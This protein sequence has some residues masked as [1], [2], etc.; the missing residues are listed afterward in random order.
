M[1]IQSWAEVTYSSLLNIWQGLLSYLPSLLGAIIVLVIGLIVAAVF[2]TAVDR[3][4]KAL[5]LDSLL[6]KVGLNEY[7]ERAGIQINSG[8]FFGLLIYWFLIVVF[9][10]AASDLLNLWGISLFL[11]DIIGYLPNII[12][13]V[14]IM[15]SAVILAK[16]LKSLVRASVLSAK[17]H[18]SKFLGTLT[19]WSVVI[20]GLLA[21]LLQLGI[22]TTII[23]TLI[24]GIIAMMALAG[25][26]A[27][28]LGG[29]EYAAHL[30]NKLREETEGE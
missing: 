8:K 5:R 12:V 23:N 19:W 30:L 20:F 24:T 22:A 26:L 29:K 7:F 28:G 10:L 27:F 4:I 3:I 16:F 2:R 15:L 21:A 6:R 13:A 1:I 18:A 17:L 11:R 25:G 9:V 14:V